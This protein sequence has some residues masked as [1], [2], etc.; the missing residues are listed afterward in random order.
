MIDDRTVVLAALGAAGGALLASSLPWWAPVALAALGGIVLVLRPRGRAVDPVADRR[1]RMAFGAGV[2]AVAVAVVTWRA[3][4][5][6]AGLQRPLPD[7]VDGVA[8]LGGDP[9]ELPYGTRVELLAGGRRWSATVP[10]ER[11][12]VFDGLRMGDRV[13]IRASASPLVGAPPGW[14]RSRHLAGRLHILQA[15]ATQG[16]PPWFGAANEVLEWLRRGAGS[17]S[18][19][20]RHLYLG[21]VVGDDRGQ[22][23]LTRHRFQVAGLTHLL[24]VSGQNVAFMLAVLAPVLRR[25]SSGARLVLGVVAVTGFVVLTRAEP[26]VLRAAAMAGLGLWAGSAGRRAPGIRV[27]GVATVLLL[28]GDP[29]L[30]HSIGFQLSLAATTALVLLAKP[31]AEWLPG[32]QWLSL[33]LSVTLAAQAGALPVMAARFGTSSI[34]A[35][36]ANLLAGPPAGIVMMAGVTAGPIAGLLRSDLAAVVQLPTRVLVWWVDAV[37]RV[38]S[39]LSVPPL[40]LWGWGALALGGAASVLLHRRGAITTAMSLAVVVVVVLCRPPGLSGGSV[41][42]GA[43]A[44]LAEGCGRRVVVL[45]GDGAGV[46]LLEALSARGI[47]H[48]EAVVIEGGIEDGAEL[49]SAGREL[50]E[51]VEQLRARVLRRMPQCEEAV[52]GLARRRQRAPPQC[53]RVPV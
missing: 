33:P 47:A 30:V 31:L 18:E 38:A 13:R 12:W 49:G 16:T 7:V 41:R 8:E 2:V 46:E 40:S 43:G 32:P 15:E 3:D 50:G 20:H 26:S 39:Q 44:A 27:I 53:C 17:F 11:E 6:L 10:R 1:A 24:A 23:D 42:L 51:V 36:P 5:D 34:V 37:A 4:G 14:V 9:E 29:M 22:S 28:S 48:V 21:L 52:G 45:D 25:C 35:L 19:P